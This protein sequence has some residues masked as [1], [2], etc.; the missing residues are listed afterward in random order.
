MLIYLFQGFDFAGVQYSDECYCG[1]E[2]DTYGPADKCD[3]PCDGDPS[4]ICGGSYAN[5]VYETGKI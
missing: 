1:K 4:E 5:S 2:Y 3:R